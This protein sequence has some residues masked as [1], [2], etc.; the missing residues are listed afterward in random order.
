[1][2]I[3]DARFY[4]LDIRAPKREMAMRYYQ[5]I[6]PYLDE[7]GRSTIV[8]TEVRDTILQIMPSLMRIFTAQ[9]HVVEFIPNTEAMVPLAEQATDWVQWIFMEDNPGF[10]S[11]HNVFKDTLTKGEGIVMWRTDSQ[12]SVTYREYTNITMEQ[13]QFTIS[14]DERTEVLKFE[15]HQVGKVQKKKALQKKM[16]QAAQPQDPNAAQQPPPD[17]SAEQ[18]FDMSVRIDQSKP[19]IIV[20]P[21]PP[22]EF[23]IDRYAK[24]IYDATLCGIET[25]KSPSE[26]I[27][28]GYDEDTVDHFR[29][30]S[31]ASVRWNEE[32]ALRNQGLELGVGGPDV[33]GGVM[34]GEYYI[35]VDKDGDGIA[36]LRRICVMGDRDE[37]VDDEPVDFAKCAYF[38]PDPEPHTA[39]GHS[40]TELVQD[41][42]K[43]K[44]NIMRNSL[45]SIA[46]TIYPRLWMVENQ[47]NIDDVLNAELGAPIRCKAPNTVGQLQ[48]QFIGD[49]PMAMIQYLDGVK[50]VRTGITEASKGLDPK[51]LQSTTVKGVDMVIT[52]AQERIELIARILAETG[53]KDMFKGLLRETVQNPDPGRVI[54][55]RG[56][57]VPIV[58]DSYDPTM[59][60]RV[61]PSLGHGS[62]TDRF[63]MLGQIAQK[64]EQ[65]I[66]AFGPQNPMVSPIEI[67]NTYEDML[68][69][70]GIKNVSRYF[71]QIDP[72][73]LAQQAAQPPPPNPAIMLAQN[74][75]QK[76]QTEAVKIN[77]D[78]AFR[79][80]KLKVDDQFRRDKMVTDAMIKDASNKAQYG[81]AA[82]SKALDAQLKREQAM[83]TMA[84]QHDKQTHDVGMN[85]MDQEHE[86]NMSQQD[87][88]HEANMAE[89]QHQQGLE[90]GEVQHA[91]GMEQNEQQAELAPKPPKGKA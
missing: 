11:L 71:K 60:V 48:S 78:D 52:G 22:D 39:I 59:G 75:Q 37:I 4:N 44:T 66:Q 42:Q 55:I 50:A 56:K 33:Q 45:D 13:A 7:Q 8:S 51:A 35:R 19:R 9:E 6:E 21:V 38:T 24:G 77:S 14:Q 43:I 53:M 64:Q 58:A 72:Q 86:Q 5:G 88:D 62:D 2:L 70:A 12:P 63:A 65:I 87:K 91:Q 25:I 54:K 83:L 15:P 1:M 89:L 73:Q 40:I 27:E 82:D 31:I 74:E 41:I 18:T 90:A 81:L 3:E 49:A 68:L 30:V 17:P 26:L 79:R 36:E 20:E 57:W 61:N 80:E 34:Y 23:R 29:G 32:R 67:R 85:A 47:V 69:C 46:S 76:T 16:Q 28:M 10:L 84:Q